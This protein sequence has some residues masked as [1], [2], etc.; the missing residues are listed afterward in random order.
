MTDEE[1][2]VDDEEKVDNVFA[3]IPG[4]GGSGGGSGGMFDFECVRDPEPTRARPGSAEKI[5]VLIARVEAGESMHHEND[6]KMFR[7]RVSPNTK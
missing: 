7:I 2:V 1:K 3:H 4:L 6:A 5:A